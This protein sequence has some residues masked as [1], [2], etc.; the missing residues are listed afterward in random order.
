MKALAAAAEPDP[1]PLYYYRPHANL[2]TT[3]ATSTIST[4][5]YVI[6]T[7]GAVAEPYRTTAWVDRPRAIEGTPE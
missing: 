2:G 6:V 1:L 3:N 5:G 4:A 7:T